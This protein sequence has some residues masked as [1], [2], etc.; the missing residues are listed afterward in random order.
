MAETTG[1]A[2]RRVN[3]VGVALSLVFLTVSVVGLSGKPWW[4]VDSAAKWIVAGT[5]ALIGLAL[6]ATAV[7]AAGRSRRGQP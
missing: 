6:L 2:R 5:I 3:V 7:P 1:P 4:F